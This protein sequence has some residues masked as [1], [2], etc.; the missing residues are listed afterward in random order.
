MM[1]STTMIPCRLAITIGCS[2]KEPALV[3]QTRETG[4]NQA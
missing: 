2:E 4:G 3:D 1:N